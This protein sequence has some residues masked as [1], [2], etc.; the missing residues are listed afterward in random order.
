[1]LSRIYLALLQRSVRLRC[2]SCSIILPG[3]MGDQPPQEP[4]RRNSKTSF[5]KFGLLC[6]SGAANIFS[7]LQCNSVCTL[8]ILIYR[9]AATVIKPQKTTEVEQEGGNNAE[10]SGSLVEGSWKGVFGSQ[11]SLGSFVQAKLTRGLGRSKINQ[12]N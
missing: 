12:M 11:R 4:V 7:K 1:M 3:T 2:R 6:A 5:Q 10:T 8:G 9:T